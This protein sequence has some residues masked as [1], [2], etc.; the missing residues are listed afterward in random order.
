MAKKVIS[1]TTAP[2]AIG[3]YSQAI[4]AGEFLFVSG[5][6]AIDPATGNVETGDI[7]SQT[8]RVLENI[9]A[10]LAA[11]GSSLE[12]VVKT[13]IFLKSMADFA[14]VNE[15]YGT[16]F[17]ENRPA[18]ATVEVSSLPKGVAVEIDAVAF[19]GE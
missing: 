7:R 18:R 4:Q 17:V 13:T 2:Q 15:V 8:K 19:L 9:R 6:I 5:Q 1:T 16:Y 11:S 10:I 14:S 3:P 12:S